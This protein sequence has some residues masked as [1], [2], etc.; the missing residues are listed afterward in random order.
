VGGKGD[1]IDETA[2]GLGHQKGKK[3]GKETNDHKKKGGTNFRKKEGETR[4]MWTDIG[5]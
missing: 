1:A 3:K 5:V 4:S 2:L